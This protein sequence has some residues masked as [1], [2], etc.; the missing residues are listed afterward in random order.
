MSLVFLYLKKSIQFLQW[1]TELI[2]SINSF[3]V[4]FWWKYGAF[5]VLSLCLIAKNYQCK[6]SICTDFIVYF[7]LWEYIY[8]YSEELLLFLYFLCYGLVEHEWIFSLLL[9]DHWQWSYRLTKIIEHSTFRMLPF[10]GWCLVISVGASET[11][12]TARLIR[13]LIHTFLLFQETK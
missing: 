6:I 2:W 1:R 7:L 3:F 12:R 11:Q 10:G 9:C 5:L 8:F 13:I 4:F